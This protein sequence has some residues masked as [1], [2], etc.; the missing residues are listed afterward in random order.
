MET[1]SFAYGM[2][3]MIGILF[4]VLIVVGVVEVIKHRKELNFLNSYIN[5]TSNSLQSDIN[6]SFKH[7]D[8][9]SLMIDRRIDG[10]ID[11]CNHMHQEVYR[12]IDSRIDKL[13]QKLTTEK[14]ASEIDPNR[15]KKLIKG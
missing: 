2:L 6:E 11:R 3:A 14:I 12:Y 5:D 10:E 15:V 7:T 1:L 4:T 8:E 9:R 13:E